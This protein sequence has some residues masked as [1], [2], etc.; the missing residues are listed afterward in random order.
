[1]FEYQNKYKQSYEDT[2][3]KIN[4][5]GTNIKND[6]DKIQ[7]LNWINNLKHF[8]GLIEPQDSYNLYNR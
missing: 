7:L 4:S 3:R 8:C 2:L 5:M 6:G 1:M